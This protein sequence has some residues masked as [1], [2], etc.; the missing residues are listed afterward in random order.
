MSAATI[1]KMKAAAQKR[2]ADKKTKPAITKT[3]K[4]KRKKVSAETI[5][6]ILKAI[7]PCAFFLSQDFRNVIILSCAREKNVLF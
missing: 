1:K 4:K 3:T 5:K 2:W 6:K 7:K